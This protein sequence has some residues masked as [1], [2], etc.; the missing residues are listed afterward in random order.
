MLYESTSSA[1]PVMA[2]Q[3]T[4]AMPLSGSSFSSPVHAVGAG[5]PEYVGTTLA[6]G[7]PRRI[8]GTGDVNP[9]GYGD[10]GGTG[11]DAPVGSGVGVM[12]AL[13][14]MY[15]FLKNYTKKSE[16]V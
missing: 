5:Q 8:P 1:M 10:E 6:L 12:L 16:R 11:F 3:S 4:S 14:L 7:G 15:V 2:F 13:A 9:A